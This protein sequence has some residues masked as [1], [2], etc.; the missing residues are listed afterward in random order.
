MQEE[1]F[2]P[3]VNEFESTCFGCSSKNKHG[4]Q[5]EFKAGS[6]SVISELMVPSHLCGWS[7]LAHGGVLTTIL[8]EVMS[9]AAMHFLKQLVMTKSMQL[10][11][12]KPVYVD[13]PIVAQ[14]KIREKKGRHEVV[15]EGTIYNES[16]IEC[17]HSEAIFAHFPPKLAGKLGIK[18]GEYP[19]WFSN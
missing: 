4:L 16:G 5:M 13:K 2:E 12:L 10:T 14:G 3:I 19:S 1:Q 15:M 18:D 8:D 17:V 11:F 7:Q 6:D 9:W